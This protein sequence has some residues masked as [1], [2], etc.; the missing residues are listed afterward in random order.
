MSQ[1]VNTTQI[2]RYTLNSAATTNAALI[3]AGLTS[4]IGTLSLMNTSA[5]ARYVRLYNK[6][7]APTVGTDVASIVI[8]I[9]ATSSKEITLTDDSWYF[10]LGLGIAITAAA[11]R[12]D[13]TI[14]AADDVSV[15]INVL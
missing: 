11:T 6:A 3:K 8:A 10:P 14:T 5:A 1:N 4:I 13:A 2:S 9:P 15:Y 7:T 12:L